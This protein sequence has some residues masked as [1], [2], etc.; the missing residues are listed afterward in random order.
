MRR[1]KGIH[2]V[3]ELVFEIKIR[4][5]KAINVVTLSS[6]TRM[7]EVRHI[8]R[9]NKIAAAPVLENDTLVGII[10]VNDYINWLIERKPDC[11]VY[12]RMSRDVKFLYEDEPLVDAIKSF[13]TFGFYE[14][15]VIDRKTGKFV[16]IISRRDV[17]MG[18]LQALEINYEEKEISSY[19]GP[20]F[21][22]EVIAEEATLVFR[23]KVPGKE[24]SRGGEVASGLKK[25][26]KYLGIHPD[27][28]RRAAIA[29]YE[30]EMNLIIYGG[31]GDISVMLNKH[32]INIE[33]SDEGPGIPDIEKVLQPGFST[34]PDWVRELGFG[35]GMGFTN[36][37]NC[38]KSFDI[39][40]TVGKGTTIKIF[41]PLEKEGC[42]S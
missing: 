24:V 6:D 32:T 7:S 21:F 26:L 3:Q 13:E 23:Y 1:L 31:G 2:K 19:S 29:T 20:H 4:D 28:I 42:N 34:A 17:I 15:P 33:I 41:I 9:K 11:P 27:I 36:I 8:L 14:F 12:K 40:S 37:Q 18:L 5:A 30:A 25:N 16:G 35:A 39:N 38:V 10:S 22:H